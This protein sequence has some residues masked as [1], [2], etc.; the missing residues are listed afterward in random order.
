MN[1]EKFTAFAKEFYN[2]PKN[3]FMLVDVPRVRY[4]M[5]EGKGD[6]EKQDFPGIIKWFYSVVHVAKPVTKKIMGK[7]F[8]YPPPEFQFWAKNPKDFVS[9]NKDKWLWRAMVLCADFMPKE[10]IDDAITE[11]EKKI[12]PPPAPAKLD[13]IHE[14]KTVQYLHFGDY[15][16]VA[17]ICEK[18]YGEYLQENNL[19]PNGYYH[20]IYLNDPTRAMPKKRK[21]IIRQPVK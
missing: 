20:E 15:S 12:G 19:I 2:P 13:Y 4:L 16:G 5:V 21:T 10:V 3:R 1:V 18:L 6:P 8:G 9:G 17:K 11:V 14:G 7:H